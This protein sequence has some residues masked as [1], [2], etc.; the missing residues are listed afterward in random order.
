MERK[1]ENKKKELTNEKRHEKRVDILMTKISKQFG[2]GYLSMPL[3]LI[4]INLLY[5]QT[6]KTKW[7]MS[8]RVA[9]WLPF[10]TS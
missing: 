3:Y 9:D 1:R 7:P 6:E 5:D 8:R 2:T 4:L 10:E